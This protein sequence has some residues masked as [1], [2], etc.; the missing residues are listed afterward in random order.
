MGGET[1]VSP[2]DLELLFQPGLGVMGCRA[3]VAAG[4]AIQRGAVAEV[5]G[6]LRAGGP[7]VDGVPGRAWRRLVRLA[8]TAEAGPWQVRRVPGGGPGGGAARGYDLGPAHEHLVAVQRHRPGGAGE[9]GSTPDAEAAR[10][11]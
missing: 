1:Q 7:G 6:V 9:P 2:H 10:D 11:D 4:T 3:P 5:V 8:H